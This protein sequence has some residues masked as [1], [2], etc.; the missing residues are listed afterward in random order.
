MVAHL[1]WLDGDGVGGDGLRRL[2]DV[3]WLTRVCWGG[4][5]RRR[6]AARWSRPVPHR[7]DPGVDLRTVKACGGEFLDV[8]EK[9]QKDGEKRKGQRGRVAVVDL[10]CCRV[11]TSSSSTARGDGSGASALLAVQRGVESEGEWREW[12][13]WLRGLGV[14][15]YSRRRAHGGPGVASMLGRGGA[16]HWRAGRCGNVHYARLGFLEAR[17]TRERQWRARGGGDTDVGK[18]LDGG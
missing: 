10:G 12:C 13:G 4:L 18:V 17:R 11:W 3:G 15:F 5:G 9:R 1:E 6:R 7:R 2:G 8:R 14:A 16:R